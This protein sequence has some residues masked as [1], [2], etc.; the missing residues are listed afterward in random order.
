MGPLDPLFLTR[1][2]RS[3]AIHLYGGWAFPL[4]VQRPPKHG[5]RDRRQLAAVT[6]YGL[7]QGHG[8]RV[9]TATSRVVPL[10]GTDHQW[11]LV[12]NA[13]IRASNHWTLSGEQRA[14][15]A[16]P[17][18]TPP[19][20]LQLLSSDAWPSDLVALLVVATTLVTRVTP[21][22][23]WRCSNSSTSASG[24]VSPV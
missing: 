5:W 10:V 22:R 7:Q 11:R 6:G 16:H 4:P 2:R 21:V 12:Q 24:A 18:P 23:F 14:P 8:C 15:T 9:I 19:S 1:A 20:T 13:R 17:E 3:V